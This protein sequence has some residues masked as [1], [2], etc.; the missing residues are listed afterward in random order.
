MPRPHHT[1]VGVIVAALASVLL[2]C[3][4]GQP[5]PP[6]APT[7]GITG[8]AVLTG[9][10]AQITEAQITEEQCPERPV[11]VELVVTPAGSDAAA[12]RST[13]AADGTFTIPLAPGRYVLRLAEDPSAPLPTAVPVT[14]EVTAGTFTPVRFTVDSGVR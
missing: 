8:I 7:S 14:V 11:E 13:T 3:G 1:G 9:C 10:P 12:A 4:E 6:A 2:A 5:G